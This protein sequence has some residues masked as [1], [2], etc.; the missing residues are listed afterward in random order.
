MFRGFTLSSAA[1]PLHLKILQLQLH[2][3]DRSRKYTPMLDPATAHSGRSGASDANL[4]TLV[5]EAL[6]NGNEKSAAELHKQVDLEFGK[7]ERA[8]G[9]YI[10]TA[11]STVAV[12]VPTARR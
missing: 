3:S 1:N 7:K 11:K 8:M 12:D 5:A 9:R 4:Q 6:A 10:S 2:F